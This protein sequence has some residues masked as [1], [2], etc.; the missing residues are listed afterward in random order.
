MKLP[1][2]PGRTIKEVIKD[3]FDPGKGRM[4]A[5]KIA[6]RLREELS[7]REYRLQE[8]RAALQEIKMTAKG[9]EARKIASETLAR[10]NS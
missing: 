1:R 9:A 4:R 7:D 3:E 5:E 10:I 8:A 2:S 6:D